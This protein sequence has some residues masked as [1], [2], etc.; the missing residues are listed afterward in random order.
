M[1]ELVAL[2]ARGVVK[3]VID[4]IVPLERAADAHRRI[5]S[6][7]STGKILLRCAGDE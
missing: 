7:A 1:R 4:S 6:R 3:P 2:Y 5:E